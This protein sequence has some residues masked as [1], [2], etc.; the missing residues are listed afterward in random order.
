MKKEKIYKFLYVICILLIIGFII[1]LGSDY[2]KYDNANNSTPFY[3][4]IVE[5]I[6]EFIIPSMI[7]FFIGKKMKERYSK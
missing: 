4:F 3:I 1:R 7:I 6:T 5:R 2:F